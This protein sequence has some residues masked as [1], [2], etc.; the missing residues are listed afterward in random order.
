MPRNFS[1]LKG[2]TISRLS[3][4]WKKGF[5]GACLIN[6]ASS[7]EIKKQTLIQDEINKTN[8]PVKYIHSK[9]VLRGLTTYHT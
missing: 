9:L 3:W 2:L 1:L 8:T 6:H 7:K 5:D 4:A